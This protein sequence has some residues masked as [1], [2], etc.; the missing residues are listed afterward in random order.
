AG[1]FSAVVTTTFLVEAASNLQ[2]NF[3]EISATLLFELQRA[4]V[5]GTSVDDIPASSF[6]PNSAFST[7]CGSSLVLNLM[8]ALVSVLVKQ[9]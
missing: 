8:T 3:T 4:I 5:N 1:L 6:S 7:A 2:P 9:W